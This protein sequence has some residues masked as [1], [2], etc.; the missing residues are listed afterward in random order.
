MSKSPPE[1][2]TAIWLRHIGNEIHVLA[3][4]DGVWKL[5]ITENDQPPYSHI[6]EARGFR[7]A[8]RDS[9]TL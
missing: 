7:D 9:I 4:I 8:K 6:A 3:E 1:P 5:V 2:V